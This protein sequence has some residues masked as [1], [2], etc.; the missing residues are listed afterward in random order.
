MS[1]TGGDTEQ[2]DKGKKPQS[3]ICSTKVEK[4]VDD[5][6]SK[7]EEPSTS[8][9]ESLPSYDKKD[10]IVATIHRMMVEQKELALE[11]LAAK[12]F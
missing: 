1:P 7:D 8:K 5:R 4:I 6:E 3:C 9:E 10:N 11:Q 12:G 2:K